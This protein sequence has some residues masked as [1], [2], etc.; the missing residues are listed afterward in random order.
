M[1]VELTGKTIG[2]IGAGN[3]GGI[4]CDRAR[5][6]KMKVLAYDPY[7]SAEKPNAWALKKLN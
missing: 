3:I 5:A 6:L 4:V 2:V 7:L 1:G